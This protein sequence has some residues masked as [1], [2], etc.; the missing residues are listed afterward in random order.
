MIKALRTAASGMIAQ[1]MNIDTIAN[2]MAN[3]NTTGFKKSKVEFQDV[4]YERVRRAGTNVSALN[5]VPVNLEVGYGSRPVASTREFSGGDMNPTDNPLDVAIQGQGFFQISMPDGTIAYTRDGSFKLSGDGRLVTADGFFLNPELTLPQDTQGVAIGIDGRL[6]V[7]LPGQTE[8]QEV[9]QIELAKFL[10]PS[11][12]EAIGHNL[13]RATVSSG[14]AILGNPSQNGFGE[15]AQGYLE[16]SNVQ[17]VDEM[18]N[19]IV[20]QRAYETNAKAI[21]TADEMAAVANELKR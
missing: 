6:Q 20:A 17:I 5:V 1:Q 8:P 10:N 12:L 16:M 21:Q 3:I 11:G 7:S 13:Y 15:L 9:G 18:V 14:D 2:N 4:L 19:M